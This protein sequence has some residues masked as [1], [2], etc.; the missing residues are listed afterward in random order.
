MPQEEKIEVE[1]TK[2]IKGKTVLSFKEPTPVWATWVFRIEFFLNKALMMYFSGTSHQISDLSDKILILTIV[3]F[4]TWGIA[5]SIGVK[6]SDV[7][8]QDGN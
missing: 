7:G 4:V 6:K 8:I 2:E 5:Q 3:D 1:T